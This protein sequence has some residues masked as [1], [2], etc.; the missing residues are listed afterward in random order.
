MPVAF[1]MRRASAPVLA[2]VPATTTTGQ[3]RLQPPLIGRV[4]T[5]P[6]LS[7]CRTAGPSASA[8]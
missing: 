7:L 6:H 4:A 3:H 2:T 5:T 1:A 8:E